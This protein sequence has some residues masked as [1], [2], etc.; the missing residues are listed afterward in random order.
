MK[1]D[2]EYLTAA[3]EEVAKRNAFSSWQ[4]LCDFNRNIPHIHY[5]YMYK[6]CELAIK[7]QREDIKKE[8]KEK[9]EQVSIGAIGIR[10]LAFDEVLEILNTL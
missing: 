4:H 7:K 8:L 9:I 2:I 6:A 10:K 3:K 1:T 5:N